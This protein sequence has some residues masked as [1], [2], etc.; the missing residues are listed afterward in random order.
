MKGKKD[1]DLLILFDHGAAVFVFTQRM[2]TTF[3]TYK[4]YLSTPRQTLDPLTVSTGI[5]THPQLGQGYGV[6]TPGRKKQFGYGGEDKQVLMVQA[7]LLNYVLDATQ[8][9]DLRY[10]P[11]QAILICDAQRILGMVMP[12][13]ADNASTFQGDLE[14]LLQEP[15]VPLPEPAAIT[16]EEDIPF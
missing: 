12:M 13:R 14:N 16:A 3:E 9:T 7:P 6:C 15:A 1:K 5:L 2:K 4:K 10:W 8:C 11:N